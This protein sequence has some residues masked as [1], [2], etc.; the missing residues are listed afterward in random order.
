M[1]HTFV[2]REEQKCGKRRGSGRAATAFA[3]AS[4]STSTGTSTCTSTPP[5]LS[6]RKSRKSQQTAVLP[7]PSPSVSQPHAT[8][9]A[10]ANEVGE[11]EGENDIGIEEVILRLS[12]PDDAKAAFEH[13]MQTIPAV[14]DLKEAVA[15]RFWFAT[16]YLG[17]ARHLGLGLTMDQWAN[18]FD[19][20]ALQGNETATDRK[21]KILEG[22]LVSWPEDFWAQLA[23]QR[24]HLPH[25][26]SRGFLT[27][28]SQV[29]G[30][31][32]LSVNDFTAR[33]LAWLPGDLILRNE[34]K[35]GAL[36]RKLWTEGMRNV[37][38]TDLSRFLEHLGDEFVATREKGAATQELVHKQDA[39]APQA[40]AR[41]RALSSPQPS[42]SKRV[43]RPGTDSRKKTSSQGPTTSPYGASTNTYD[44]LIK[45]T[46]STSIEVVA[47]TPT[48]LAAE[49]V[50]DVD[51]TTHISSSRA[52]R[53]P[54]NNATPVSL[55]RKSSKEHGI[56]GNT[57]NEKSGTS[58]ASPL[59]SRLAAPHL[60]R[61][62][63]ITTSVAALNNFDFEN[64]LLP[65]GPALTA[66]AHISPPKP[67]LTLP[68]GIEPATRV[69][70]L[71][72]PITGP[73]TT[74]TPISSTPAR[75]QPT[76][77]SVISTPRSP[78]LLQAPLRSQI[79]C[80][81]GIESICK[82]C[83]DQ[84]RECTQPESQQQQK[85]GKGRGRESSATCTL[86][87]VTALPSPL[88]ERER[89]R[90]SDSDV[91]F[92]VDDVMRRLADSSPDIAKTAFQHTLNTI[93]II[94][95]LDEN[96]AI[97]FWF[98]YYYFGLYENDWLEGFSLP[99]LEGRDLLMD[100]KLMS[101]KIIFQVWPN[102]FWAQLAEW[103]VRLPREPSS[104]TL[105][106]LCQVASRKTLDVFA[107]QFLAWLPD[108][109]VSRNE[110]ENSVQQLQLWRSGK[111]DVTEE[112]LSRFLEFKGDNAAKKRIE[113]AAAE[114][115]E[116]TK[117][118]KR[119]TTSELLAA[120]KRA[121]EKS[122]SMSS[123]LGRVQGLNNE[124][125][126]LD[127][128]M[129][130]SSPLSEPENTN[131]RILCSSR[132]GN[133]KPSPLVDIQASSTSPRKDATIG[134][135]TDMVTSTARR[136]SLSTLSVAQRSIGVEVL[137]V[138]TSSEIIPAP[139]FTAV[140]AVQ[141]N[142]RPEL[143]NNATPV[144][145]D[146]ASS[147]PRINC[148]QCGRN[149]DKGQEL[150]HHIVWGDC[151]GNS[152]SAS[153]KAPTLLPQNRIGF[154]STCEQ[155]DWVFL[156][157]ESID[158]HV[159]EGKCATIS[160][161][162]RPMSNITVYT[163][164]GQSMSR[165]E[166]V[167]SGTCLSIIPNVS[168]QNQ[169]SPTPASTN[170]SP[171]PSTSVPSHARLLP[172]PSEIVPSPDKPIPVPSNTVSSPTLAPAGQVSNSLQTCSSLLF[173]LSTCK[174]RIHSACTRHTAAQDIVIKATSACN[175]AIAAHFKLKTGTTSER[176]QNFIK[177][178]GDQLAAKARIRGV[179][180]RTLADVKDDPSAA[181]DVQRLIDVKLREIEGL[182][183]QKEEAEDALANFGR[184]KIELEEAKREL[185]IASTAEKE[186][187]TEI[188]EKVK[189]IEQSTEK[190]KKV[191][192]TLT[193]N[194]NVLL[195]KAK[196]IE[197]DV[198][199]KQ[200]FLAM[201]KQVIEQD[202]A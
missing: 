131:V 152:T 31:W 95:N 175:I 66:S 58:H 18:R 19:V 197:R 104:G 68:T 62:S 176:L 194:A 13:T 17:L 148:Q 167:T 20:S 165:P 6:T 132:T 146:D 108:D 100:Q 56:K 107:V 153:P 186:L 121:K 179:F 139:Q 83:P 118:R 182:T 166:L 177:D 160:S 141:N 157:E 48:T 77:I 79:T 82:A 180:E 169:P 129:D 12:N 92:S 122:S 103:G 65:S 22:I 190:R 125:D 170:L 60:C 173:Q 140:N 138:P 70:A 91:G 80:Y 45:S 42:L 11:G 202:K 7:S 109:L 189:R 123:S 15:L 117:P 9:T 89:E 73:N 198:K 143:L 142:T 124:L 93:P 27:K 191:A 106:Q 78:R 126:E 164:T 154:P 99:S 155:C 128:P 33:F 96:V 136:I 81:T 53:A 72:P 49:L 35:G 54:S 24:V 90:D 156:N 115:L 149:F 61:T 151:M 127:K 168:N 59:L 171:K 135:Q 16:H 76:S 102:K 98:A 130:P 3:S 64:S 158:S 38:E 88:S 183:K 187:L 105:S 147:L 23:A 101:I 97:R 188:E 2:A 87:Q 112:D 21:L 163:S 94:R 85:G 28:L 63:S 174:T 14:R 52:T 39:A 47:A 134:N 71:A 67:T 46:A 162:A 133:R 119:G 159:R 193:M 25:E 84:G 111:R 161:I 181:P 145:P 116:Q 32:A 43:K 29:A 10:G 201:A 196:A 55:R 4:N 51:D 75:S 36:Q 185:D 41:K 200:E 57:S 40:V 8:G 34:G 86:Q 114:E 37:T 5:P 30:R 44:E 74:P 178:L 199:A 110:R 26:P 69:S 192:E 195:D 144:P 1:A 120:N 50:A 113:K 172:K 150:Y 184:A 137:H